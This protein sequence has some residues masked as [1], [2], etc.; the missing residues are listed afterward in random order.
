LLFYNAYFFAQFRTE[1]PLQFWV[2]ATYISLTERETKMTHAKYR[3]NLPQMNGR[4]M[5][6]DGGMETTL[7]FHDGLDLPYFASFDLLRR[8]DGWH[9]TKNYYR[10]YADLARA[11]GTGFVFETPTWR[12]S[13]DWGDLLGYSREALRDA[14]RRSVDLGFE[15]RR[16]F[17]TEEAPF[18][19]SGNLG[20]RGDGYNPERRMT[21]VEAEAYHSEQIDILAGS[22]VDLISAF[23]LNYV[24]EAVGIA[25]A[26]RKAGVPVVLSYTVETDGRLPTGQRLGEAVNAVDRETAGYPVYFMINCAHPTHFMDAVGREESWLER[27]GGI[28]ANASR[29]SHAELDNAEELDAGDPHE[30]GHEYRELM[31]RL[32]NL[33]VFGGCCGTDIRHV[34]AIH[35]TCLRSLA[36]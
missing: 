14:N 21:Q 19:I 27:I 11:N 35:H 6:T 3:H 5:L 16:E 7:I 23:T 31:R 13:R 17:E 22:G 4:T 20:P 36:A 33:T 18:V 9:A 10:Q 30:F 2:C 34:E 1:M 15:I 26:A 29:M 24:E 32:P 8:D 25:R 28:R 12:A